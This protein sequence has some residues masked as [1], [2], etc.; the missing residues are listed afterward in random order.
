LT[1]FGGEL[2]LVLLDAWVVCDRKGHNQFRDNNN[3]CD[4]TCDSARHSDVHIFGDNGLVY[5]FSIFLSFIFAIYAIDFVD[6]NPYC[7]VLRAIIAIVS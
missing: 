1:Q 3:E 5:S 2:V 4:S 6:E 7:T